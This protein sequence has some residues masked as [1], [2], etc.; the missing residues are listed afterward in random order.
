MAPD[1]SWIDP[2]FFPIAF[3][4]SRAD[5][6]VLEVMRHSLR[7]SEADGKGPVD[8]RRVEDPQEVLVFGVRPVPAAISLAFS[9]AVHHL[10]AALETTLFTLACRH[11]GEL[12]GKQASRVSF[13]ICSEEKPLGDWFKDMDRNQLH[14]LSRSSTIGKRVEALQPLNS[15][16]QVLSIRSPELAALGFSV[17]GEHPLTLLQGYSN[18][19]KHRAIR[20]A[21]G[22]QMVM[23]DEGPIKSH[24]LE[25]RPVTVGD[26]LDFGSSENIASYP[27][28]H[29]SR[30]Q[31]HVWVGPGTE[32]TQLWSYVAEVAIPTLISGESRVHAFPAKID[33][34]SWKLSPAELVRN[35]DPRLAEER[36]VP[37]LED[38]TQRSRLAGQTIIPRGNRADLPPGT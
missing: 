4:L 1:Y 14:G 26:A 9:D 21:A 22:R 35:G 7:W 30:P 18:H 33:T 10:R 25:M 15:E 32:L 28:V 13:P 38:S 5:A 36:F 3:R 37:Y 27:A 2:D 17:D 34:Q 23:D 16:Q 20:V 31:G 24:Q 19:D 8:I 29:V 12:T 11:H 6:A